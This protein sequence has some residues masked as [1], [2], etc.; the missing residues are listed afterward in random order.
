MKRLQNEFNITYLFVSHDIAIVRQTCNRV[1]VMYLGKIAETAKVPEL[2]N[3]PLHPYT[4]ALLSSVPIP[5]PSLQRE[6][7]ILK[8][9]VP[10]PLN[11]PTGCRFHPRCPKKMP[12]CS[13]EEPEVIEV[14]EDHTVSCH[15][16]R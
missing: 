14:K 5:D 15:L 10:T 1:I 6:R 3:E 11:P 7:I 13:V 4:Q 16:F 2:F 9:D 8:G 12:K